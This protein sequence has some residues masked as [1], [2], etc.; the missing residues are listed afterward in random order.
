M[1][2]SGFVGIEELVIILVN[3]EEMIEL[4]VSLLVLKVFVSE[5]LIDVGEVNWLMLE[6]EGICWLG[7]GEEGEMDKGWM[8]LLL[9]IFIFELNVGDLFINEFD[10]YNILFVGFDILFRILIFVLVRKNFGCSFVCFNNC[11]VFVFGNDDEKLIVVG[12]FEVK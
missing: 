9:N 11:C 3:G 7:I 2:V 12:M 5:I 4:F 8:V 6:I 10:I 1:E